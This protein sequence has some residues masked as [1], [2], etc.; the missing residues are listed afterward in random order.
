MIIHIGHRG[1]FIVRLLEDRFRFYFV[2]FNLIQKPA[3]RGLTFV[4]TRF[5]RLAFRALLVV[6]SSSEGL[7]RALL[8]RVFYLSPRER[9]RKK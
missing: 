7:G 9:Y 4:G 3:A 2:Q 6:T 5:L 8:Y 1:R